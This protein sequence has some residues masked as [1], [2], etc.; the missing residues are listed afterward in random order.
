MSVEEYT[1]QELKHML[2]YMKRMYDIVRLVDPV[3]CREVEVDTVGS[4]HYKNECYAVWNAASRCSNCSSY[5]ACMSNSKQSKTED[6]EGNHFTIQS[7]PIRLILPDR[8]NFSCVLELITI[9]T[10]AQ[11]N[12]NNPAHYSAPIEVDGKQISQGS[13]E[14][15]YI[16]THDLLTRLYNLDGVCREVR[17]VLVDDPGTPRLIITGDIRKFRTLND[18]YG[19]EKGNEVLIAIADMMR[20]TCG[21]DSIYGRIMADHFVMCIP[22]DH[23]D[24]GV[25]MNAIEQI[26]QLVDTENYHLYFHVGIYR[27]E[28]PE[29]PVT[30]MINR[31][32]MALKTLHDHRENVLTYYTNK[33]LKECEYEEEFLNSFNQKIENNEFCIHIQPI[34]TA[35]KKVYAAEAL[36]RLIE[37]TGQIV[38]SDKYIK[39]LEKTEYIAK[40]DFRNWELVMRQLHA[41]QG[42][43]KDKIIMTVNVS[44]KDFYYMDALSQIKSLLNSYRIDPG[45]IV[46]E[47]SEIDLMND[48]ESHFAI[49][50]QF[51]QEG[52]QVAIDNFGAGNVSLTMLKDVNTDYVKFDKR[53]VQE[54]ENDPKCRM[55]LDSSIKLAK[56]LGFKTVAEGIETKWQFEHLKELGCDYFQGYYLSHP[57]S[58]EEF[59]QNY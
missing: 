19:R 16:V 4:L 34:F 49:I 56:D 18:R 50:D 6:F 58:I 39:I 30:V 10:G 1:H 21:P 7:V 41:W 22:E 51:R 11:E 32:D 5:R 8:N 53:F 36:S 12:N 28:D 47:I 38:A 33:L 2:D 14:T 9:E 57:I 43:D 48:T 46:I 23:F 15:D 26:G 45:Q 59:E 3:E 40:L 31:A 24:E 44:P 42:S 37:P 17:R 55:I 29:L 13:E 52:F 27:I 20:K 25:L 54:S 35:D